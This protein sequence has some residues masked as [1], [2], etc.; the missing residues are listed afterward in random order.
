MILSGMSGAE[1]S[2]VIGAYNDSG[3]Q[4]TGWRCHSCRETEV[5]ISDAD[6]CRSSRNGV[7]GSCAYELQ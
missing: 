5:I 7:G 3:T 2:E 1:V 4:I 6:Y